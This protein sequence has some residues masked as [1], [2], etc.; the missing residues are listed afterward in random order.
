MR[1]NHCGVVVEREKIEVCVYCTKLKN[2][3][4]RKSAWTP[5]ELAWLATAEGQAALAEIRDGG[6]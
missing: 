2:S 4:R 3:S 6:A 5:D 1:C